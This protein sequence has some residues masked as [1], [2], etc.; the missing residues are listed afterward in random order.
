[1]GTAR[2]AVVGAG[3][4]GC[5]TALACSKAFPDAEIVVL[6]QLPVP[7]G[8]VRYG[9]AAD[10]QGTKG[11][12]AQFDRLF[13][14]AKAQFL[15]GIHVGRDVGLEDLLD[16]FDVVV[17]A[18]GL[19]RDRRLGIPGEDLPGA[20]GSGEVTRAWNGH[21]LQDWRGI[22]IG[23]QVAV[24][25]G[26]NVS[27]DLVRLLAKSQA[28]LVGS[29]LDDVF[30][31]TVPEPVVEVVLL[32]RA[33]PPRTRWDAAVL[34]ELGSVSGARVEVDAASLPSLG[35]AAA[36]GHEPSAALADLHR[37][38]RSG[39]DRVTVRFLFDARPAGIEGSTAVTGVRIERRGGH[40]SFAVD[41]VITAIGFADEERPEHARLLRAG[42][43]ATGARGTIPGHR[44]A[45]R[46]LVAE[47]GP[48]LPSGPG[49]VGLDAF[50]QLVER[51]V[52]FD[53]WLRIDAHERAA[54]PPDRCRRKVRD[55]SLLPLITREVT[56]A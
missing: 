24:V 39:I 19:S 21:P 54:A 37:R 9:V 48:M 45:A 50:P 4:A 35:A 20:Y 55:L 30:G 51:A 43:A 16:A 2:I 46:D 6:D 27:L 7:Y 26:G 36:A 11:V 32:V 42:W 15:G 38:G 52:T 3:P 14:N 33:S 41:T 22:R 12:V 49:R 18:G 17:W 53:D 5:Y 34:R 10:H 28:D 8:L 25:G 23:R 13:R 56:H 40:E 47:I 31:V 1:M 44:T 29:D